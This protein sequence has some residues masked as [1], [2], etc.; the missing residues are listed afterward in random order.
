[1]LERLS[2]VPLHRK[3]THAF[4]WKLA[5]SLD[6]FPD[7]AI[8]CMLTNHHL[9]VTELHDDRDMLLRLRIMRRRKKQLKDAARKTSPHFKEK[10]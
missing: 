9:E 2:G 1:M 6:C 8:A 4:S 3:R 5:H 7:M 10:I